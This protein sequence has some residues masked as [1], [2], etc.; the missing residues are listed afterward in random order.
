MISV[1]ERLSQKIPGFKFNLGFSGRSFKQGDEEE[2]EGDNAL[3]EHAHKF[4]WFGH[5]YDH[6]QPHKHTYSEI[7]RSLRKNEEFAKVPKHP[8]NDKNERNTLDS[9]GSI[10]LTV[11]HP[12]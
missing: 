2:D 6:E 12:P 11:L 10:D 4:T 7:V 1:Q 3:L 9:N 8:A 5:L